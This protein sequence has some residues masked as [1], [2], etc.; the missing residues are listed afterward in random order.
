MQRLLIVLFAVASARGAFAA[1]RLIPVINGTIGD[2]TYRTTVDLRSPATEECRFEFRAPGGVTLHAVEPVEARKPKL[3]DEFASEFEVVATTVRVSCTGSVDVL[4]RIHES[5]DGGVTFDED[6]LF[7]AIAPEPLAAG[8]TF[9]MPIGGDFLVAEVRGAPAR[10]IATLTATSSNRV[11]DKEYDLAPF[12]QRSIRMADALRSLGPIN[13]KFVIAGEGMVII[14]PAVIDPAFAN[15]AR[16]AP[17]GIRARLNG[18]VAATAVPAPETTP[19]ITQQLLA[20]PFKAAPF[21]DPATG[22]VFMRNRWYDPQTGTFL[23]PDP[24]GYRD[25]SNPYNYC[26]GDPVNCSDPDG[27]R[28]MT[29]EDKRNLS[30]LKARGKRLYDDFTTTGRGSFWQPM[31]VP[32]ARKWFDT[33]GVPG[34]NYGAQLVEATATTQSAYELAKRTMVNDVATFQSA[35]AR[36]DADGEILYVPGQGF[37][38]ITTADQKHAD[39]ATMVAAAVFFATDAVPMML[40]PYAMRGQ[41]IRPAEMPELP[42]PSLRRPY[43][44]AAFCESVECG[45]VRTLEGLPIDPNTGEVIQG[46]HHYGHKYGYEHRRLLR[47]ALSKGMTQK[48]FNDWINSHPEWF[49]IEAPANNM[50]HKFEKPG[51]D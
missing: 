25:S 2:R 17:A 40:S 22:L 51:V 27:L 7:R 5:A 18:Q 10:V 30:I 9:A 42:A 49:Q 6:P 32:V 20:S 38:T 33:S 47:E 43:K 41:V 34:S 28:A 45:T 37:T 13:A 23:T 19:S 35:I 31:R 36:A 21:R 12:G 16:R 11:A 3:L 48:A 29:A 1:D 14:L 4:S 44:R 50:S 24:E 8:Q 15:R 26:A 39:R 46:D